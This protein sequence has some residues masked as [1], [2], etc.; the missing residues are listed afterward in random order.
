M[1]SLHYFFHCF[2]QLTKTTFSFLFFH[3]ISFSFLFLYLE[4]RY[5]RKTERKKK[6]K[7]TIFISW[8]ETQHLRT[9]MDQHILLWFGYISI[10]GIRSDHYWLSEKRELWFLKEEDGY[11]IVPQKKLWRMRTWI[12]SAIK[13]TR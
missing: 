1:L 13:K 2:M 8:L 12:E 9:S 10:M 5:F 4:I 6:S 7:V 3:F 11:Q